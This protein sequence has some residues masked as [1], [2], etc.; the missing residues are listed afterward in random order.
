VYDIDDETQINNTSA[1]D[2]LGFLEFTLHEIVTCVD[3]KMKKPLVCKTKPAHKSFV[4]IDA[5]EVSNN[6]NK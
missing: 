1:H 6:A 3:Q 4:T 2:H 5:E